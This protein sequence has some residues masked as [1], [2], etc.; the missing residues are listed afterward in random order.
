MWDAATGAE[1][2]TFGA[3]GLT[4]HAVAVESSGTRLVT[5]S[6]DVTVRDVTYPDGPAPAPVPA[7]AP[8]PPGAAGAGPGV[9]AA[10]VVGRWAPPGAPPGVAIE[11]TAAG[12]VTFPT[13]AGVNQKFSGT[14]KVEG[15]KLTTVMEFGGKSQPGAFAIVRVTDDELVLTD[16][17]GKQPQVRWVRVR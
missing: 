2:T 6:A 12:P 7:P 16:E 5:G 4:P 3:A 17:L 11:F 1:V 14:Y 8:K 10:K 15:D 9:V 13:P